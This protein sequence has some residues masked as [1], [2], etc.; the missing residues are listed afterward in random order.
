MTN[1]PINGMTYLTRAA[2]LM[3]TP[4][5]RIFVLVPLLINLVLFVA[6]TSLLIQ[7]FG[8]AM[9]W[10][11]GSLPGWL[12][13]LAW[14]LWLIFAGL[15]LIVYGYSFSMITNII[16]APFYGILAEKTEILVRGKGPAPESLGHMIPR[17][18]G[19]ELIKLWYFIVRGLAILILML[20]LSFIP[21]VN[22]VAPV[23]G[24]LWGAWSMAIQY[25][26]YPADNNQLTFS[27]TRN[28]LWGHK[29]SSFSLGSLIMLGTMIPLANIFIMPIA[30]VGGTLFWIDEL[31]S[32]APGRVTRP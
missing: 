9:S 20:L 1:H 15:I 4:K 14:I 26:D 32:Q 6:A 21:L 13:F 2:Q 7:Q 28:R 27:E 16:A 23:I 5:L 31:D 30:V 8:V 25:V 11:L 18:L 12:D 10:L 22:V 17:T 24:F 3:V 19:R 29:Y